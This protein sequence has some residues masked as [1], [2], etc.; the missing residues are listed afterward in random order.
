MLLRT[1]RLTATI[2]VLLIFQIVENSYAIR[3]TK[4]AFTRAV[5]EKQSDIFVVDGDGKNLRQ[6]T[7]NPSYNDD[8]TWSPD[9]KKLAFASNWG[10]NQSQIWVVDAD[11]RNLTRL[12]NEIRAE[13]PAWSPDGKRIAYQA[14]RD[15]TLNVKP[16]IQR[17]EICVID[18]D[19]SNM[20]NLTSAGNIQ[21][22]WSPGGSRIAFVSGEGAMIDQIYVMGSN[23]KNKRQLTHDSGFKRSPAWSPDGEHIAYV[24]GQRIWV[25][26]S[27]GANQRQL[28]SR[29][30]IEFPDVD[31]HPTWSPDGETIAFHSTRLDGKLRIYLTDIATGE[32]QSLLKIEEDSSYQ[33][34][35]Y[36][37]GPLSVSPVDTKVTIWGR[38]KSGQW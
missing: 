32:I 16:A 25:M 3:K 34:D 14:Q 9:G 7:W 36:H 1:K 19:G 28:T 38:L 2:L 13:S 8:P 29:I 22:C 5:G 18:A 6:I 21:P 15:N 30:D 20:R 11:R 4:I 37:P 24:D 31:G 27:N 26:N 23:G 35:W 17:F 10:G 33:P 12:T